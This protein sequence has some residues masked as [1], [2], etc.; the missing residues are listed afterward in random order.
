LPGIAGLGLDA[1]ASVAYGPEAIV[2]VLAD[3]GS[4]GMGATVPV[5]IAN[6]T[7]SFRKPR[8]VRARTAEA[9]LGLLLGVL[10]IGL[11]VVIDRYGARPV[12]GRTILSLVT[13]GSL[14]SGIGYVVVQLSTVVLLALAANTSY[15]GLP[16][17]AAKLAADD[18]LP[19]VFGLRADRMVH[20]Y[21]VFVL[22]ALAG[23]LLIGTGGNVNILVPLFAI[24]VFAGFLLCQVGMFRHWRLVRGRAWQWKPAF[25]AFGAVLTASALVVVTASKFFEGGW[26]IVLVLPLLVLAFTTVRR[27]YQKIGTAIEVDAVPEQPRRTG[28]V[29][30]VPVVSITRLAAESLSAAMSMGD[31]VV[32]VHVAFDA[33]GADSAQPA[34]SGGRTG[35]R[36]AYACGRLPPAIPAG[37]IKLGCA[38]GQ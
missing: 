29:V 31:R 36:P 26:L 34:R 19:H 11:A 3:A 20:R 22:A 17:L 21:G 14:G 28:C 1:I 30:V 5:T 15:D 12:E 33:M 2:L 35:G 23:A 32:A 8:Q 18:F 6:A 9:G 27:A 24:G 10:L 25:S 38:T 37:V 7:P 13:E 4:V 16:V